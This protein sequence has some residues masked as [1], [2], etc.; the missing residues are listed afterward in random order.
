MAPLVAVRSAEYDDDDDDDF[1]D[2]EPELGP[3]TKRRLE[4]LETVKE[5]RERLRRAE[6]EV[7]NIEEDD[8]YVVP[9]SSRKKAAPV[10]AAASESYTG[11]Q[12]TVNVRASPSEPKVR[13]KIRMDEPLRY[14]FAEYAA[15]R[16][17]EASECVF[18]FDGMALSPDA[19]PTSA[20]M[21]DDDL[22]DVKA[23]PPG[24]PRPV[25]P[26]ASS[27]SS[28]SSPPEAEFIDDDDEPQVVE[29]P[30]SEPS[31]EYSRRVDDEEE[32]FEPAPPPPPRQTPRRERQKVLNYP[33]LTENHAP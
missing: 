16:G 9:P 5:T 30:S 23:P 19:T 4:L 21:E 22:L 20:D 32:E 7:V 2:A 24:D 8:E 25:P 10:T 1:L 33:V 6:E 12:V 11:N 13:V 18:K 28:S 31:F 3:A 26:R 15:L 17:V 14:L 27:T 29:Q